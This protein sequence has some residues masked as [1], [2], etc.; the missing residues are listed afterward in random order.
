VAGCAA[1]GRDQLRAGETSPQPFSP[2]AGKLILCNAGWPQACI[3]HVTDHNNVRRLHRRRRNE[4]I[5]RACAF[6]GDV[7]GP[8][9]TETLGLDGDT[10]ELVLCEADRRVLLN[11]IRD[12]IGSKRPLEEP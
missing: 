7:D 6:C 12:W 4:C 3:R 10:Y 1:G 2:T 9:F 8:F 11:Q 5:G